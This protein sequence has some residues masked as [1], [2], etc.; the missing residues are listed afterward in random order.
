[1]ILDV[2]DGEIA[3]LSCAQ[4]ENGEVKGTNSL[5]VFWLIFTSR[6]SFALQLVFEDLFELDSGHFAATDV[7]PLD[8]SY[9]LEC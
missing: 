4:C 9:Y 5:S 1:M 7:N 6:Y 2:C 8:S 3:F